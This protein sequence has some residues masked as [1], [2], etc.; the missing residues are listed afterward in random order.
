[1]SAVAAGI[2]RNNVRLGGFKLLDSK[3]VVVASVTVVCLCAVFCFRHVSSR[4]GYFLWIA[5]LAV[6]APVAFF[7]GLADRYGGMLAD[8][9][10]LIQGHSVWHS[11]GALAL[12][13]AYQ[14]Y[15]TAGFDRSLFAKPN[16]TNQA[17]T[18]ADRVAQL[19]R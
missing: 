19:Q 8:P 14:I 12:L 11:S 17:T 10:A 5:G 13:C 9:E 4:R 18:P 16:K 6:A 7:G 1:M 2:Y 3:Y 15:A